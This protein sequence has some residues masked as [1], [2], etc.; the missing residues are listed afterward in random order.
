MTLCK[1]GGLVI[2]RHNEIADELADLASKALTPSA[3][4]DKPSIYHHGRAA[5]KVP[6]EE[7]RKASKS[8]V[9]RPPNPLAVMRIGET[10]Y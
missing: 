5:A 10:S 4:R 2:I 1:T 9:N 7:T 3:V 6:A 8:P